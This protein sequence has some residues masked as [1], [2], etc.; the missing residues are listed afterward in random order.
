LAGLWSCRLVEQSDQRIV[1]VLFGQ[2]AGGFSLG[3]LGRRIRIVGQQHFDDVH[4]AVMGCEVKGRFAFGICGV[5]IC[6]A[7]DQQFCYFQVAFAC[8]HM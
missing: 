2:V 3:G 7:R 5:H 6:T 1:V 8:R 4:T